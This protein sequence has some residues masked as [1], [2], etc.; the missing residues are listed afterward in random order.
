MVLVFEKMKGKNM[1]ALKPIMP[2][3]GSDGARLINVLVAM[4]NNVEMLKTHLNTSKEAFNEG[5]AVIDEYNI[6]Q[7]TA[8]ALRERANNLWAKALVNPEEVD[9]VHDFAQA[10]YDFSKNAT[11]NVVLMGALKLSISAILYLLQSLLYVLPYICLLY[12][13]DAAD[14]LLCVDLGGR[15]ILKKKKR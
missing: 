2:L 13:S 11:E 6:Q 4:G 14:D 9:V 3:L 12:T 7:N 10:W 1:N 15:R 8:N 5:R